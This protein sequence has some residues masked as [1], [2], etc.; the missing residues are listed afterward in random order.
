MKG[1][2]LGLLKSGSVL[3]FGKVEEAS[4]LTGNGGRFEHKR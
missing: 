4:G 2:P 1:P 3:F